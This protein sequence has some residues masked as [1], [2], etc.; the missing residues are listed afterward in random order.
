M[1][2]MTPFGEY[3]HG[4][5]RLPAVVDRRDKVWPGGRNALVDPNG[6]NSR[7]VSYRI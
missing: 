3:R 4:V 1:L 5:P 6:K 7:T 2:G